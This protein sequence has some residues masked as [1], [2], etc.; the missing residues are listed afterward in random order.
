[1]LTVRLKLADETI[2]SLKK[3]AEIQDHGLRIQ[4]IDDM[5]FVYDPIILEGPE[6]SYLMEWAPKKRNQRA[7]R[8]V[9]MEPSYHTFL[10]PV[11]K[12]GWYYIGK[13]KWAPVTIWTIWPTLREKSKAKLTSK[14]RDRCGG[15][16]GKEDIVRMMEE[17]E[18]H[19]LGFELSSNDESQLESRAFAMRMGYTQGKAIG[20]GAE[21]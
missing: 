21:A 1:M 2:A 8:Y 10:F 5:A 4:T 7:K 11:K 16:V 12:G 19:Q 17:G 6:A 13:M 18:L 14:L 3:L 20:P 9:T 15:R